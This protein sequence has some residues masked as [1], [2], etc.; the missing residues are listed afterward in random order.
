[1]VA[2]A[3]ADADGAVEIEREQR[4][5][6][7]HAGEDPRSSLREVE[8]WRVGREGCVRSRAVDGGGDASCGRAV[9][10]T[11]AHAPA[12]EACMHE[13]SPHLPVVH[14]HHRRLKPKLEEIARHAKE[15]A[16]QLHSRR[17]GH[18]RRGF[19]SGGRISGGSGR[20]RE[21][22]A[23]LR[24][25]LSRVARCAW[26]RSAVGRRGVCGWCGRLERCGDGRR[27]DG[28]RG[29]RG[30]SGYLRAGGADKCV[31]L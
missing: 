20:G 1:M 18:R 22:P 25:P 28:A 16:S 30:E 7:A 17:H 21:Q 12:P 26:R 27:R 8:L 10:A 3:A 6:R 19:C 11:C 24:C 9:T 15:Q 4:A 5:H 2:R 14:Y 29:Q 23:A 31:A 13:G